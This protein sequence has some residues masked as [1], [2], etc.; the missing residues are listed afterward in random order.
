MTIKNLFTELDDAFE[1]S[2]IKQ[3]AEKNKFSWNYSLTSTPIYENGLLLIGFNCGAAKNYP[4]KKQSGLPTE[5]F[6]LQDLGSFRRVV[7]YLEKYLS[8]DTIAKIVQT[9]YCF[10]RSS[11]QNEIS[12]KDRKLC[13]P[14]FF[15][16][17][18][19]INP[20][21]IISFSASL[22]ELLLTRQDIFTKTFSQDI[23]SNRGVIKAIVGQMKINSKNIPISFLP[24][25]NYPLNETAH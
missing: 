19:L 13:E 24:H 23:P 9:N 8:T 2:D 15:K 21:Q 17:V 22:R 1:Q 5:N 18:S 16:L 14:I 12:E 4:Y 10:F 3:Y 7:P 20:K 11:K 25:P 6:L